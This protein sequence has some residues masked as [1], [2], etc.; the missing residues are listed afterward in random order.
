MTVNGF[1]ETRSLLGVCLLN[2]TISRV[3]RMA[4]SELEL[5]NQFGVSPF[6]GPRQIVGICLGRPCL[7]S[8]VY[9]L[10]S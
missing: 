3:K 5:Q 1:M 4:S 10:E 8:N 9:Y 7:W 6:A 2:A